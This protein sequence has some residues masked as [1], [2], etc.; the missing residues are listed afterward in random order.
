MNRKRQEVVTQ[1]SQTHRV[2]MQKNLQRRLEAARANGDEEL[3]RLLEAEAT[4]IG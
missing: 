1:A 4:Y 2:N 3:I